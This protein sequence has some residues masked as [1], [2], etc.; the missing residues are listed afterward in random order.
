VSTPNWDSDNPQVARSA[1]SALTDVLCEKIAHAVD[2]FITGSLL[3]NP[4][5]VGKP[6][7]P[8]FAPAYSTRPSDYRVKFFIDDTTHTVT[9]TAI[10]HRADAYRS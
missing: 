7:E 2:E 4:Q 5:R 1:A 6:L 8:P 9:V 10:R 3:E